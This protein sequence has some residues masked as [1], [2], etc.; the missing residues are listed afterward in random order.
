MTK[1]QKTYNKD[2]IISSINTA[3]KTGQRHAKTKTKET[4]PL[5]H[6]I[7]KNQTNQNT[8]LDSLVPSY[9]HV[10]SSADHS[11]KCVNFLKSCL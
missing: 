8:V 5:S 2:R 10:I 3:R 6:M 9:G 1:E 4:R 7:L 11:G